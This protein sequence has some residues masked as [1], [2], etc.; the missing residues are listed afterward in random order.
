[1]ALATMVK[2]TTTNITEMIAKSILTA[3]I[4]PALKHMDHTCVLSKSA[5]FTFLQGVSSVAVSVWSLK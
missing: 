1:M 3:N 4:T 5:H 2:K